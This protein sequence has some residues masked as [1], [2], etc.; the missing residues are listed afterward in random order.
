M[1]ISVFHALLLFLSGVLTIR[2]MIAVVR[3]KWSLN[4]RHVVSGFLLVSLVVTMILVTSYHGLLAFRMGGSNFTMQA[5]S[6][7]E[8]FF[9]I[10]FDAGS[11]GSRVHVFKFKMSVEGMMHILLYKPRNVEQIQ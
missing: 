3:K 6:E 4:S 2:V 8:T 1:V 9:G 5:V 7:I 10:M 11:T